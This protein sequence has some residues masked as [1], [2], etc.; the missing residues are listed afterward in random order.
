MLESEFNEF[1]R[2]PIDRNFLVYDIKDRFPG[3]YFCPECGFKFNEGI[4]GKRLERS[5]GDY[6]SFIFEQYEENAVMSEFNG[7]GRELKLD[8]FE[9]ILKS[10]KKNIKRSHIKVKLSDEEREVLESLAM[11]NSVD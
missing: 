6:V 7:N 5:A 11:D 2:C 8:Y 9:K 3:F 1:R 10:F 4:K